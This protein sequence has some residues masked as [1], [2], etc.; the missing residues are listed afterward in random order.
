[1]F[2]SRL[3]DCHMLK[4][5]LFILFLSLVLSPDANQGIKAGELC[6]QRVAALDKD[7]Y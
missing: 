6:L 3:Q 2:I 1:M 5:Q 7:S 4:H